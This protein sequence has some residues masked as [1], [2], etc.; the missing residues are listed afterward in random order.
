MK[1]KISTLLLGASALLVSACAGKADEA[2]SKA[3]GA[4]AGASIGKLLSN[5]QQGGM[6]AQ[7]MRANAIA[8]RVSGSR[9]LTPQTDGEEM[10]ST[11]KSAFEAEEGF[12]CTLGECG[13]EVS[14]SSATIKM[15]VSCTSTDEVVSETTCGETTYSLK[16]PYFSFAMN[17]SGNE[18]GGSG[19]IKNEF[20]GDIKGGT[21]ADYTAL[22]CKLDVDVKKM[23]EQASKLEGASE[24]DYAAAV[25]ELIECDFGGKSIDMKVAMSEYKGQCGETTDESL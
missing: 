5:S 21:I 2:T 23:S 4:A 11:L 13:M 10:C 6:N 8:Q 14:G 17:I 9:Q 25:A 18:S 3:A 19:S 20:G 12:S 16:K 22:A 15:N 24:E 1:I 7:V